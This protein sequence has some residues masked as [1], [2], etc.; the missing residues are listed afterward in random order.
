MVTAMKTIELSDGGI[1]LY[2]ESFLPSELADRYFVTIRDE[3]VWEQKPGVFGHMQPRLTASYGDE[4]VTYRY[5]YL[6]SEWDDDCVSADNRSYSADAEDLAEG[7][8][9]RC[10]RRMSTVL[11]HEGVVL[12]SVEDVF[13]DEHKRYE[14]SINGDSH[15]IYDLNETSIEDIWLVSFRRLVEIVNSLLIE[16]GSSERLFGIYGGNDARVILLTES[17]HDLI[18]ANADIFDEAWIPMAQGEIR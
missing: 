1:L 6:D 2:D 11:S 13:T 4:G 9:G 8:L 17:M 12:E 3:C 5:K 10:L 15:L 16:A 7:D 18:H 14:V